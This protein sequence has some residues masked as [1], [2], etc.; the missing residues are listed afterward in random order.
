MN[1][2]DLLIVGGGILGTFHAYHALRRG[3]RVALLERHAQPRGATVR[4]FGQIVPSGL[5][6]E[7]Q[8]LGRRGLELY[9]ELQSAADISVRRNGSIYLASDE[10]EMQ[11]IEELHERNR[12][13]DYPSLLLT[14]ATCRCRYP[15]LK[16][17]YCRGGLFFPHELTVEPRVAIQRILG[18]LVADFQLDYRPATLVREV[19]ATSTG[20]RVRD[21]R[22]ETYAAGR[23]I[24]CC[25]SE[26]EQLFPEILALAQLEISQLQMLQSAPVPSV[27]L[28]GSILTGWSIRRYESFRECPSYAAVKAG[29]DP[30]G[31]QRHWGIHILVKQAPDGSLIIGDSHQ[32]ADRADELP[33]DTV[34]E[35][36]DFMLGELHR[37]FELPYLRIARTWL[38]RYTQRK[39]GD[40]FTHTVDDRIHLVTGIGGKGMTAGP[41]FA[42]R[43]LA[44]LL[45]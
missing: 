7:W 43:H 8:A 17:D 11:L 22:G 16:S 12:A 4:N 35:V 6:T 18:L 34:P 40:I 45:A 23:V 14:T 38:G 37:I 30:H 9:G 1:H 32:Y 19:T 31:F 13:N 44:T 3:L 15:A 36:N 27:N 41:A 20:C 28:P 25:G 26:L 39:T 29:E 42:E 33:F 21:G 5:N 24:I 10:E 2:Y